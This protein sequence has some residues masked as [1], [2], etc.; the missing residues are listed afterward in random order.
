MSLARTSLLVSVPLYVACQAPAVAPPPKQPPVLAVAHAAPPIAAPAPAA[1]EKPIS[2][3][4]TI[5][6]ASSV[7]LA[8]PFGGPVLVIEN[9]ARAVYV[10]TE[11]GE[12]KP[13][14]PL[15]YHVSDR[16]PDGMRFGEI[17]GV[18]P[19]PLN[20]EMAETQGRSETILTNLTLDT[21]TGKIATASR[22]SYVA[23]VQPWSKG[24]VLALEADGSSMFSFDKKTSFRV[25][26]GPKGGAPKIPKTMGLDGPFASYESGHVFVTGETLPSNDREH[27]EPFVWMFADGAPPK[28]TLLPQNA[29]GLARGRTAE[30]TMIYGP[31]FAMRYDGDGW[32]D[33]PLP[34]A[35]DVDHLS[36]GDDGTA[37]LIED[38][39]LY[40]AEFPALAWHEERLPDGVRADAV[41]ARNAKDVWVVA[42]DGEGTAHVLH[43]GSGETPAPP[44]MALA[45]TSDDFRRQ[46]LGPRPARAYDA[47]C[48]IPLLVVAKEASLTEEAAKKIELPEDLYGSLR[49]VKLEDGPAWAFELSRYSMREHDA[50]VALGSFL[51]KLK[52]THKDAK[53]LCTRRPLVRELELD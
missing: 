32:K 15:A 36:V 42:S 47:S 10:S 33:V 38:R 6:T 1:P 30:E 13:F 16:L 26:S 9:T 18:W 46:I 43:L 21:T 7:H 29:A 11:S 39:H 50:H 24:R 40:R 53:L 28:A 14:E 5:A 35:G 2:P 3:F 52:R 23:G 41:L 44:R 12:L 17:T 51:P 27:S 4:A 49:L 20:V 8:R 31:G 25:V 45:N 37:W 34:V 22:G 48:V 19:G